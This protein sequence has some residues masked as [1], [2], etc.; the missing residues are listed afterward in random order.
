M[1]FCVYMRPSNST[2]GDLND[3]I[4]CYSILLEQIAK[5]SKHG[6][7]VV[8]GDMN[9]RTADRLECV[10]SED[11]H[12][13]E[14]EGLPGYLS[15]SL[16]EHAISQEDFMLN[17]MCIEREI[18]DITVNEYGIKLLNLCYSSDVAM[19]N[20]RA[21]EDREKGHKTFQ[22]HRGESTVDYVLCDKVSLYIVSDFI[23]HD[24]NSL[25]DHYIISFCLK[26]WCLI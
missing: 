25:S 14:S 23:I 18:E 11:L 19:L 4:D 6:S 26:V 21:G 1:I 13:T 9:T 7:V 12:N 22:N 16:C 8:T 10:L 2:R 24:A 5:V 3:G 20:G 15:N 17:N